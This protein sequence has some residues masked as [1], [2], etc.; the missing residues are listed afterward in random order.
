MKH[1]LLIALLAVAGCQVKTT[2]LREL[3]VRAAGE[4]VSEK[5]SSATTRAR[6]LHGAVPIDLRPAVDQLL[7]DLDQTTKAKAKQDK[8]L[9]T[10]M[11]TSRVQEA[12]LVGA[13]KARDQA[14]TEKS[15]VTS[16]RWR[17]RV[18][19]LALLVWTFR[20]QLLAG[21]KVALR[22]LRAAVGIPV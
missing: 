13:V 11:A 2:H 1:L 4:L 16:S 21:G 17:W 3:P 22:M 9:K 10:Y 14:I 8:E 18:A 12:Q 7:E 5:L 20:K 15:A 19:T 6:V